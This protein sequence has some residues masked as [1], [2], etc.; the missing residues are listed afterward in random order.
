MVELSHQS[1]RAGVDAICDAVAS[2][3]PQITCIGWL[4]GRP[5]GL[6][7]QLDVHRTGS[8]GSL[9]STP[10]PLNISLA[11]VESAMPKLKPKASWQLKIKSPLLLQIINGWN[12][13]LASMEIDVYAMLAKM[14]L[15]DFFHPA[16]IYTHF[17]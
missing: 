6:D 1:R 7:P 13:Y 14:F 8:H 10:R 12:P 15:P 2:D 11:T 5:R 3:A 17:Y 9:S 4:L 16:P